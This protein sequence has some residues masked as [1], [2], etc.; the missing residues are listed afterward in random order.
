MVGRGGLP[1]VVSIQEPGRISVPYTSLALVDCDMAP[2]MYGGA[3]YGNQ[4][5]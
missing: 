3:M 5:V 4:S 1:P 2:E